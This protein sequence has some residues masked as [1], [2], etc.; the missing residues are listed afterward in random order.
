[1]VNHYYG[2]LPACQDEVVL[3]ICSNVMP[4]CNDDSGRGDGPK[5]LCPEVCLKQK[6]SDCF[7]DLIFGES[8]FRDWIENLDC[9]T[10]RDASSFL[11]IDTLS[12]CIFLYEWKY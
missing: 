10:N 6:N 8:Q 11:K 2:D 5:Q 9:N 4:L 3:T 7:R 1:M 12:K